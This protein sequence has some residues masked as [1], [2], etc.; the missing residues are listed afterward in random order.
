[1]SMRAS[2][3]VDCCC[4]GI[5]MGY[6]LRDLMQVARYRLSG[7]HLSFNPRPDGSLNCRKFQSS[8]F[9]ICAHIAAKAE[10]NHRTDCSCQSF[11]WS[12]KILSATAEDRPPF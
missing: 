5:G 10:C 1:M 2:K 9:H 3:A 11:C 8:T 7:Y 6:N 4:G 12:A